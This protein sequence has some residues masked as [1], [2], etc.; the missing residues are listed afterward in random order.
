M[1]PTLLFPIKFMPKRF[2]FIFSL[3]FLI[4]NTYY[5]I[6]NT[7]PVFAFNPIII[8]KSILGPPP[9]NSSGEDMN[10]HSNDVF[11]SE[12]VTCSDEIMISQTFEPIQIGTSNGQPIFQVQEIGQIEG[13]HSLPSKYSTP[14][15]HDKKGHVTYP[16]IKCTDSS[17]YQLTFLSFDSSKDQGASN[18]TRRS[19]PNKILKCRIGQRLVRAVESLQ[20]GFNG[21]TTNEQI[22]WNCGGRKALAETDGVGCTPIRLADV[23]HALASELVFYDP[24]INCYTYPDPITLPLTVPDPNP[25]SFDDALS[26]LKINVEPT[27]DGS[28]TRGIVFTSKNTGNVTKKI[29]HQIPLG[30]TLEEKEEYVLPYTQIP[31]NVP[32]CSVITQ[33]PSIDQPNPVNVLIKIVQY[34]GKVTDKAKTFVAPVKVETLIPQEVQTGINYDEAFL[35][36]LITERDINA[37]GLKNQPGS[38]NQGKGYDPGGTMTRSVFTQNLLPMNF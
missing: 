33:G 6:R 15:I 20:P 36:D 4:L 30:Q 2:I 37:K 8:E 38:S 26:L 22:A 1:L 23:A 25:L 19:T 34:F 14:E 32:V 27:N 17:C 12:V 9:S 10:Y 28:L 5:L 7:S 31:D 3:L 35:K 29:E 18:M 24:N 16:S 21:I 13:T 11:N